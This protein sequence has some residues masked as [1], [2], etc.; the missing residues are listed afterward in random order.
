MNLIEFPLPART[1]SASPQYSI[2]Y[3]AYDVEPMSPYLLDMGV[4]LEVDHPIFEQFITHTL[5]LFPSLVISGIVPTSR[6]QNSTGAFATEKV[7]A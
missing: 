3:C 5:D 7:L 4:V 2:S 1:V 6:G